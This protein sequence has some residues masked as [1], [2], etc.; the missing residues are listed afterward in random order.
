MPLTAKCKYSTPLRLETWFKVSQRS[1]VLLSG[2]RGC[3]GDGKQRGRAGE[4]ERKRITEGVQTQ[5]AATRS[6]ACPAPE[7]GNNSETK[8]EE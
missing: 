5:P 6:G 3:L 1:A 8:T 4:D 7:F 2:Q